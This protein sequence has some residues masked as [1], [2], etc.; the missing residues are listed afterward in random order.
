MRPDRSLAKLCAVVRVVFFTDTISKHEYSEIKSRDRF[1]NTELFLDTH[2]T[3]YVDCR[4]DI[5]VPD[6]SLKRG[7]ELVGSRTL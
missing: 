6:M 4:S 7:N 3:D 5:E 1:A 2:N